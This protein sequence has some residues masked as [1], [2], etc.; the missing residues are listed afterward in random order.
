MSLDIIESIKQAE[1]QAKEILE[2]AQQ[3]AQKT[4]SEAKLQAE[5][6][7]SSFEASLAKQ[8][9]EIIQS[10]CKEAKQ[11]AAKETEQT[12]AKCKLLRDNANANME[13]AILFVAEKL[14]GAK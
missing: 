9:Q 10:A 11:Q 14:K 8:S 7:L 3:N 4:I 2:R 6:T 1:R 13:K 12:K 5:N